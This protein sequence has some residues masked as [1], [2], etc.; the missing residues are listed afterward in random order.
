MLP[1]QMCPALRTVALA[2]GLVMGLAACGSHVTATAP[3]THVAKKSPAV[4]PLH[5]P[6]IPA[7]QLAKLALKNMG[8]Q[9][10]VQIA[11][12]ADL[13][14]HYQL[15]AVRTLTK[16]GGVLSTA[17]GH[18]NAKVMLVNSDVYLTGDAQLLQA[19]GEGAAT[20]H[21]L[22]RGRWLKFT[23]TSAN[24]TA[25]AGSLTLPSELKRLT[26]P[27]KLSQ[28]PVTSIEGIK[29]IPLTQSQVVVKGTAPQYETLYVSDTPNPLPVEVAIHTLNGDLL[30]VFSH[31]NAKVTSSVPHHNITLVP[32]P[33]KA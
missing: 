24:Y 14:G 3:P 26:L 11:E 33:P 29:V 15:N 27:P 2:A 9:S 17:A 8:E 12:Q 32:A 6:K 13:A 10:S 23:P 7:Q 21:H 19:V 4:P 22:K 28:L 16:T 25:A 31:W 5:A 30:L 18:V 20:P 1:R